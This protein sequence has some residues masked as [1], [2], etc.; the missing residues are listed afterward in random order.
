MDYSELL[1]SIRL[2]KGL[3]L[4]ALSQM[5]GVAES[6]INTW[7]HGVA[8]PSIYN[9]EAVLNAMGLTLEITAKGGGRR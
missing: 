8:S 7:E 2:Q 4:K 1:K 3:T 6:T 5:S 9:Y